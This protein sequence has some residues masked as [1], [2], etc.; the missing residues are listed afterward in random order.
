MDLY[1]GDKVA[2]PY[3]LLGDGRGGNQTENKVYP[4]QYLHK[5]EMYGY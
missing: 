2:S 1:L 5:Q 3:G 4:Q